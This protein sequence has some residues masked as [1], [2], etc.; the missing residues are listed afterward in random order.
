LKFIRIKIKTDHHVVWLLLLA[1]AWQLLR[2]IALIF[3]FDLAD[4]TLQ[5][6]II[7]KVFYPDPGF[8]N[9]CSWQLQCELGLRAKIWRNV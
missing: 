4:R 6:F 1:L 2:C 9:L 8:W 5:I 3:L 7:Q